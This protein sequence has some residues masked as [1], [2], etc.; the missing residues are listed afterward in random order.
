MTSGTLVR[1]KIRANAGMSQIVFVAKPEKATA[2]VGSCIAL[3]LYH[4]RTG[5]G[6]LAHIVLPHES[7]RGG[8]PGKFADTAVPHLVE[9]LNEQ[10]ANTAGLVAKFC[11][12]SQMFGG[13]GPMQIGQQN[14][15]AVAE[16]LKRL[17]IPISGEQ[18][19]GGKGR[20][21]IFDT[22]SGEL[23][24]EIPGVPVEIL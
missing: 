2:V 19:G 9:K 12:G 6:A 7:G 15:K 4:P 18:V 21:V 22:A 16:E 3:A 14:A 10:G 24:I 17:R 5:L 20:R 11:G 8:P 13:K 1:E 23:K